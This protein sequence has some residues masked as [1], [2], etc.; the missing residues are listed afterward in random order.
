MTSDDI[1]WAFIQ[2]SMKSIARTSIVLM[3]VRCQP[4]ACWRVVVRVFAFVRP[5]TNQF[6][7]LCLL[8]GLHLH[9][10]YAGALLC[11]LAARAAG[12]MA[13]FPAGLLAKE[14]SLLCPPSPHDSTSALHCS[15]PE[16]PSRSIRL[17]LYLFFS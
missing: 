17:V 6:P 9:R 10:A 3:Q 16:P 11:V 4:C 1:A 8:C 5:R 12:Y 14:S 2:E 15:I 7:A 13:S